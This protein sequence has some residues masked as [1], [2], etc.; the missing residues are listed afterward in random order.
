MATQEQLQE[1]VQEMQRLQLAVTQLF[2]ENTQLKQKL[3]GVEAKAS[4]ELVAVLEKLTDQGK[5]DGDLSL[6]DT[7]GVAK[8]I[9]F[10]GD[11]KRF[12]VW[13]IKTTNFIVGVYPDFKE[14][15]EWAAECPDVIGEGVVDEVLADPAGE[16]YVEDV[17]H[18]SAQLYSL[19]QSV[20]EGEPFEMSVYVV[21]GNGLELWRRL[22][23]KYDPT[24]GH[25]RINILKYLIH[26]KRE[27]LESLSSA[28]E[29]WLDAVKTYEERRDHKDERSELPEDVK[30]AAIEAMVP[31]ELER[32]LQLNRSEYAGSFERTLEAV[33]SYVEVRQGGRYA[34]LLSCNA[35]T[36]RGDAMDV[37]AA[38]TKGRSRAAPVK[39]STTGFGS[40]KGKGSGQTKKEVA[41]WTCGKLG[42][43]ARECRSGAHAKG[44]H[45]GVEHINLR[46]AQVRASRRRGEESPRRGKVKEI[47]EEEFEEQ[48]MRTTTAKRSTK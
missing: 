7:R 10:S 9:T 27:T 13:M 8:P 35:A 4:V 47:E 33:T 36:S 44:Q 29:R 6:V 32:H 14:A 5:R 37:S 30:V 23:K 3:D 43:T 11:D 22:S 15:L 2:V 45:A 1:L 40:G 48:T 38:G 25:R 39:G 46:R 17:K 24:T 20:L 34:P 21:T 18:K 42:H 12:H 16:L 19:L 31:A 26:P 41:C 28:I